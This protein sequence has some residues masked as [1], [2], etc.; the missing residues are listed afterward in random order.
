MAR[1]RGA[2][3]GRRPK[4]PAAKFADPTALSAQ[5]GDD[6]VSAGVSGGA[7]APSAAAATSSAATSASAGLSAAARGASGCVTSA[8]D[9]VTELCRDVNPPGYASS[10]GTTP[11]RAVFAG[12]SRLHVSSGV[13]PSPGAL[14]QAHVPAAEQGSQ[15]DPANAE[16]A[17]D[18]TS[19]GAPVT[20]VNE[21]SPTALSTG[22]DIAVESV[23][24]ETAN[25][26]G[27]QQDGTPSG[28]H[29]PLPASLGP[30]E[31]PSDHKCEDRTGGNGIGD[32]VAEAVVLG[33]PGAPA[34]QQGAPAPAGAQ[35]PA[36]EGQPAKR[37]RGRPPGGKNKRARI[38]EQPETEGNRPRA[39]GPEPAVAAT[40]PLP[41][42]ESERREGTNPKPAKVAVAPG[43]AMGGSPA[44]VQRKRGRPPGSKNK[45]STGTLAAAGAVVARSAA[46]EDAEKPEQPRAPEQ[47]KTPSQKKGASAAVSEP[48]RSAEHAKKT[49]KARGSAGA[50]E[51]KASA[52][53]MSTSPQQ[54]KKGDAGDGHAPGV[55][56]KTGGAVAASHT[57]APAAAA[58]QTPISAGTAEGRTGPAR[59]AADDWR[60]ATPHF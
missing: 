29:K 40:A 37:K 52:E 33:S 23:P 20:R 22:P 56:P 41:A 3:P 11:A 12:K 45:G 9:A 31:Q 13:P 51:P 34:V 50:V 7:A 14:Q 49:G 53:K 39:A 46:A 24:T 35:L 26:P 58:Q 2:E 17:E 60:F 47:A 15:E 55:Q 21:V 38:A 1:R 18:V 28:P 30:A 4:K 42:A 32:T 19:S 27:D 59:T 8:L 44:A 6:A 16:I 25:E 5:S 36:A 43:S 54:K 10:D 48:P 57:D